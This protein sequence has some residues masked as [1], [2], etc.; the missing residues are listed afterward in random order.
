MAYIIKGYVSSVFVRQQGRPYL[1]TPN[2]DDLAF[3]KELVE[4]GKVTPVIDRTY[5]LSETSE[6]MAYVGKGRARGKVV[7][8][9][10]HEPET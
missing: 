1:A 5:P 9:V 4:A 8:S 7:I 3:L 2:Q 10:A 6:A